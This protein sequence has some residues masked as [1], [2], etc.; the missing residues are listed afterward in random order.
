MTA[1]T[2]Q[3]ERFISEYLIDLNALAAYERAGWYE[4]NG[5]ANEYYTYLLVDPRD[6]A[7][8]YV[9]K[10]KGRRMRMHAKH[11]AAGRISNAEK[12]KRI[13]EIHASGNIV[14]E[15]VFSG[16][17]IE[18]DAYAVERALIAALR[19]YGLT[20]IAGGVV[21]NVDLIREQARE[22]IA[23]LKPFGLWMA[24]SSS[25][26]KRQARMLKGSESE[27]YKYMCSSLAVAAR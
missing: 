24:T 13:A 15:S 19:D 4:A 26:E 3:Q 14:I 25:E 23:R 18:A 10:G 12:H 7:V 22:L 5:I 8:F 2:P 27:F 11:A 6:G 16:H 20:N 9:G 21:S 1:L 17:D